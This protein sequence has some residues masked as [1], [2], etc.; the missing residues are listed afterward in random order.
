MDATIP[1]LVVIIINPSNAPHT[2]SKCRTTNET[3]IAVYTAITEA[4]VAVHIVSER[5]IWLNAVWIVKRPWGSRQ[6]CRVR[7]RS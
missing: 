5:F 2:L 3:T 1:G 4:A 6:G 7:R